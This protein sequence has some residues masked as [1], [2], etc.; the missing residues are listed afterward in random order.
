MRALSRIQEPAYTALRIVVGL[1][2][3]IHGAQKLFGFVNPNPMP[4]FG[5]QLW[6]GGL[7]E[8]LCGGLVALGI[9]TRTA[10]FLASGTMAVAYFQ[11]HFKGDFADW[12]WLPVVN[13]GELAAV[14][15]FV[16]LYI[17]S[18]G[19]GRWALSRKW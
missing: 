16:F 13:K 9:V 12:S 6:W 14:F 10:A 17:A 19:P 15:S 3:A 8:L 11:F 4:H 2:L 1:F 18:R 7:I 5:S